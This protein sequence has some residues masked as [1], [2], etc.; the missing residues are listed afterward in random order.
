MA[1]RAFIVIYA[2]NILFLE[3]ILLCKNYCI[4]SKHVKFQV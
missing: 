4:A 1:A 3:A 2:L